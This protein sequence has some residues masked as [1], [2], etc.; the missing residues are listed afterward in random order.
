MCIPKSGR[1]LSSLLFFVIWWKWLN[2]GDASLTDGDFD[3]AFAV[4]HMVA[5]AQKYV[6]KSHYSHLQQVAWGDDSASAPAHSGGGVARPA[7]ARLLTWR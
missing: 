7:P 5:D 1:P 2:L 3:S 4:V 6:A